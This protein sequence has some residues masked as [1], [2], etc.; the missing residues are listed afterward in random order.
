MFFYQKYENGKSYMKFA[1]KQDVEVPIAFA[2]AHLA[3]FEMW[4]R[5]AMRRGV[6]VA[7]TD[8]MRTVGVGISWTASFAYRGKQRKL[9]IRLT[10]MTAPNKLSFSAQSNALQ[11][12]LTADLVEMSARRSRLHLTME[13]TPRN[14]AARLFIQS[15]RLARARMDRK[16]AMRVTQ[17]ITDIETAYREKASAQA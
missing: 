4:E 11:V 2:F 10:K 8:E 7:R 15:M 3:D 9:D 16:F 6:E 14:L 12:E 5:A 17:I 1:S 13:V